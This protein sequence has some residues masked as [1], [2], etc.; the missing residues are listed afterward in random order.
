MCRNCWIET[1]CGDFYQV[2]LYL[3][4]LCWVIITACRFSLAVV[5]SVSSPVTEHGFSSCV[6]SVV[7]VDRLALQRVGTSQTRDQMCVPCIARQIPNHWTTRDAP[8]TLNYSCIVKLR[9][10][11]SWVNSYFRRPLHW[12]YLQRGLLTSKSPWNDIQTEETAPTPG[13]EE[14]IRSRQLT[15]DAGPDPYDHWCFLNFLDLCI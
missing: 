11:D 8:G 9:E 13:Q 14:D 3:F 5:G 10:T 2:L 15:Q 6:H 7:V 12:T 1:D 4:W